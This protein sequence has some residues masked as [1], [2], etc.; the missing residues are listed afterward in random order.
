MPGAY[1]KPAY[2]LLSVTRSLSYHAIVSTIVQKVS[3]RAC[4]QCVQLE[5]SS[6]SLFHADPAVWQYV[7]LTLILTAE[8]H[9]GIDVG[10]SIVY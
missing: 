4:C 7:A 9:V 2:I 1:L 8:V 3:C 6:L 10:V 5:S